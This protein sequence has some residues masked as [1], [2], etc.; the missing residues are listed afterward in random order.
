MADAARYQVSIS[1]DALLA[2]PV[3]D[4]A[5]EAVGDWDK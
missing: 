2:R 5:R 4:A 1:R 3:N